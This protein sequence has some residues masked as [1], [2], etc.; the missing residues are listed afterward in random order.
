MESKIKIALCTDDKDKF[1]GP[2]VQ[3]L[4]NGIRIHGSV[5]EACERM[6]LSYSKGRRIL[7]NAEA[8]LGYPLVIRQQGGAAGGSARLTPQAEDFMARYLQLTEAVS[9]YTKEQLKELF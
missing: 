4:L 6:N 5:K 9:A 3:D 8:A 1:Y 2:G 7:K